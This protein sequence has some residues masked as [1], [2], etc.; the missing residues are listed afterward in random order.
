ML[1][2]DAAQAIDNKLYI[3]GG[4]W[5]VTGPGPTNFA[6]ALKIE[7]PWDQTNRTHQ[8]RM[9]LI[10]ADGRQVLLAGPGGAQPL[11][12]G[13]DFEVGR[14]PGTP[15]GTPIDLALSVNLGAVPFPTGQRLVW[16]LWIDEQT[17]TDW[18]VAFTTRPAAASST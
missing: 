15:D 10:D 17:S 16:K 2:A 12:V 13:G 4:G 7:V 5:S 3:L 18:E 9:E 8:W 1:L 6:M 11:I 14:P